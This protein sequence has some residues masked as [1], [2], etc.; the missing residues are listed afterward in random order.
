MQYDTGEAD[1]RKAGIE[2]LTESLILYEGE[3]FAGCVYLGGRAVESM[4]RAVIWKHDS[5][6]KSGKTALETGHDLRRLLTRVCA[7]GV[8]KRPDHREELATNIQRVARVWFNNMRFMPTSRM[9][10]A[11][12]KLGEVGK[13]RSLKYAVRNFYENCSVIVKRCETLCE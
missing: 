5:E 13:R 9:E 10:K 8:L 7:L 11:W 12:W 6:I 4:L 3:K 1:Y 2:R